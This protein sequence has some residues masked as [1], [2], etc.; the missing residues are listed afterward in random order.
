MKHEPRSEYPKFLSYQYVNLN[1]FVRCKKEVP[2]ILHSVFML[3][4]N[5]VQTVPWITELERVLYEQ[6][7]QCLCKK[8]EN[9]FFLIVYLLSG[10]I[11]NH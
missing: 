3:L 9:F 6:K 5:A 10:Y 7:N 2:D 1:N 11:T 4:T 8:T